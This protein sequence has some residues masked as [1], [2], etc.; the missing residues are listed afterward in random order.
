M[1][2]FLEFYLI[3]ALTLLIERK[4][5]NSFLILIFFLLKMLFFCSFFLLLQ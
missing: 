4:F 1:F 2:T 3:S 5:I